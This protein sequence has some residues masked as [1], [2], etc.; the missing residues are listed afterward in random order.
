MTLFNNITFKF[1]SE[2]E[3]QKKLNK[4]LKD[5]FFGTKLPFLGIC[6]KDNKYNKIYNRMIY[7]FNKVIKNKAIG[8]N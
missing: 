8:N 6:K 1:L 5:I 7:V 2:F 3:Y 4:K